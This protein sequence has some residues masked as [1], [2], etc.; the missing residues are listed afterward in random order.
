M[1]APSP[2]TQR[3]A[4]VLSGA[5]LLAGFTASGGPAPT[6]TS[7]ARC[8]VDGKAEDALA[9]LGLAPQARERELN[10]AV[11]R[12]YSGEAEEAVAA[13]DALHRREARWAPA[14]RWLARAQEE[15]GQPEALD[16][17]AALLGMPGADV[18]DRLWAGRLFLKQGDLPRARAAFLRAVGDNDGLE[19]GWAGLAEAEAQ[20]GNAEAARAASARSAA[21]RGGELA[22]LS[23]GLRPGER[24]RYRAKYLFLTLAS[25]TFETGEPIVYAGRSAHKLVFSAKSNDSIPFFRMDSR[26]ESV[27]AQDG[28]VLAHRHVASDSDTGSDEAVYDMDREG[29]RCTVRTVRDGL[30]GYEVLP[31]PAN[32][33]D[34]VSVLLVAR[35]VARARGSAVVP[36]AVDS[37]W[38]PTQLRTVGIESIRWQGHEVQTVRVQ[39][40]GHYRGPG[41]LSGAVDI[42]VSDDERAVPYRVR[43]K[44]AVGSVTLELLPDEATVLASAPVEGVSR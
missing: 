5:F 15:L 31:L 33:Q 11:V 27:V 8:W 2:R 19:L 39:A 42:W 16:S 21:L 23:P 29:L 41:G 43:M 14:L 17:A 30:F 37:L 20:L 3:L 28:A 32:A 12:L 9:A 40:V 35:A 24:L 38:W 25:V 18:R 44:V 1:R 36:T 4:A 22:P 10:G 6:F 7:A 34:G 13:L 26:F